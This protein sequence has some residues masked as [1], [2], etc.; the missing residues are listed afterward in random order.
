[1]WQSCTAQSSSYCSIVDLFRQY[2][3]WMAL[4]LLS[5]RLFELEWR[6][7]PIINLMVYGRAKSRWISSGTGCA[8]AHTTQK[9]TKCSLVSTQVHILSSRKGTYTWKRHE[10]CTFLWNVFRITHKCISWEELTTDLEANL[11]AKFCRKH[12]VGINSCCVL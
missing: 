4:Q 11:T 10:Y 8:C 7:L 5:E 2:L 12:P 1:M 6:N 3:A 9:S